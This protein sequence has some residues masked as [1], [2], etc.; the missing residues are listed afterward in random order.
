[1]LKLVELVASN[2]E[3]GVKEKTGRW[4]GDILVEKGRWQGRYL[5][6]REEVADEGGGGVDVGLVG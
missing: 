5:V 6:E 2:G 3:E 1:M 4:G